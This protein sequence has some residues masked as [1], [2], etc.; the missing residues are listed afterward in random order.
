VIGIPVD[1]A[2]AVFGVPLLVP[3][4]KPFLNGLPTGDWPFGRNKNRVTGAERG[5][6]GGIVVVV[7][8]SIRLSECEELLGR[9]WIRQVFLLGV[10]PQS[11]A[12]CQSYEGN[13]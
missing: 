13:Y 5:N 11:E 6:S 10:S 12:D 4:C 8:L 7:C 3:V 9:L 1:V 2:D